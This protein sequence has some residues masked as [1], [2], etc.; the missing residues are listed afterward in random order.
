[1]ENNVRVN[2]DGRCSE[3]V[4]VFEPICQLIEQGKRKEFCRSAGP[5]KK[6]EEFQLQDS[7]KCGIY[8]K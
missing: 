7:Q 8:N 5:Q 4:G 3:R 2:C 6:G 1:M